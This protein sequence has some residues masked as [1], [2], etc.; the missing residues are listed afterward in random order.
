MRIETSVVT[1]NNKLVSHHSI[2]DQ[3]I[4]KY[5]MGLI[6]NWKYFWEFLRHFTYTKFQTRGNCYNSFVHTVHDAHEKQVLY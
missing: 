5:L 1:S 2:A 6:G 3:D 4:F